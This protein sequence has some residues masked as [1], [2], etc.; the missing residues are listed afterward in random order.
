MIKD[1]LIPYPPVATI[2][3][4][5]YPYEQTLSDRSHN[6]TDTLEALAGRMDYH[7]GVETK[8]LEHEADLDPLDRLGFHGLDAIVKSPRRLTYQQAFSLMTSVCLASNAT[9]R[10]AME[11]RANGSSNRIA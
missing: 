4:S 11:N 3:L 2:R 5:G 10:R 8:I 9:V 7:R 6:S 1:A